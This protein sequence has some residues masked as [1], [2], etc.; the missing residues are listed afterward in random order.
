[1][2]FT[3]GALSTSY[4]K[5][6]IF[7]IPIWNN[8]IFQK[9]LG[10]R[11]RAIQTISHYA[12]SK[13]IHWMDCSKG[14]VA[15]NTDADDTTFGNWILAVIRYI[16]DVM[17]N[18]NAEGVMLKNVFSTYAFLPVGKRSS[19]WKKF[20]PEHTG[21][22]MLTALMDKHFRIHLCDEN[23]LIRHDTYFGT[24]NNAEP[25]AEFNKYINYTL[26]RKVVSFFEKNREFTYVKVYINFDIRPRIKN[27]EIDCEGEYPAQPPKKWSFRFVRIR[28]KSVYGVTNDKVFKDLDSNEIYR[29]ITNRE[30]VIK[31]MIGETDPEVSRTRYER[32][33]IVIFNP[34]PIKVYWKF[35]FTGESF[36]F[37]QNRH[38]VPFKFY[39]IY[40][41]FENIDENSENDG[42]DDL[43]KNEPREFVEFVRRGGGVPLISML[44][45]PNSV[46]FIIASDYYLHRENQRRSYLFQLFCQNRSVI[47]GMKWL[48]ECNERMQFLDGAHYVVQND[49]HDAKRAEQVQEEE[50]RRQLEEQRRQ[51]LV[52]KRKK[53]AN[54]W[55]KGIDE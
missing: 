33:Q 51:T 41:P 38:H 15:Y 31:N 29:K 28:G 11:K 4:Y 50:N 39:Y 54:A 45:D 37:F 46:D 49:I 40:M 1:L 48:R 35:P 18:P 42:E 5:F 10:E 36:H 44:N 14:V 13:H 9:P 22:Y 3:P 27:S 7:D 17:R 34:N 21:Q 6:C 20:K 24:V 8:T 47:L 26:N 53:N 32:N 23:G 2:F 55:F 30:L 16:V 12:D 19:D 43:R 25:G 52:N